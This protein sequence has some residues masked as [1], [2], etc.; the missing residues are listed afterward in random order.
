MNPAIIEQRQSVTQQEYDAI[1]QFLEDSCGI[2]LGENKHYLVNSRLSRVVK[3]QGFSSLGELVSVLGSSRHRAVQV[4]V[5]DAMTT[6]ET[7]WFRDNHPF[8][9]LREIILPDLSARVGQ[10]AAIWSAACS[11]GQE[12]YSISMVIQEY[13]RGRPN[14][15]PG[16]RIVA[17][18]ISPSMLADA[19]EGLFEESALSR[20]LSDEFKRRYFDQ[21]DGYSKV[22][23]VIRERITFK[24]VNLLKSFASLGRFDCIFCRNVLIYFSTDNK[25]DI[26]NRLADALKPEGYLYLGGTESIASFTDRFETLRYRGG[27]VYKLKPESVGS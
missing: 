12:P 22:K 2:V 26:I 16:I 23:P 19:S 1:R 14:T 10:G 8:E 21:H 9:S 17:T 3:E 27:M 4:S 25:K 5:I 11:S 15:L 6:N 20:G 18:D 24:E 7:S 13:L